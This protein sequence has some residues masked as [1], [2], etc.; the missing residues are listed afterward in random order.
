M[1][2]RSEMI[3]LRFGDGLPLAP[4]AATDPEAL[5]AAL[6]APDALAAAFPRP[7]LGDALAFFREGTKALR[8]VKKNQNETT[9]QAI[10][11]AKR[12]V[13]LSHLASVQ[14]AVAR[15]V[16][17]TDGFRE[18]LVRF[19]ADHF[20]VRAKNRF[21]A[22]FPGAFVD[23]AIRPNLAADFPTLLRAAV[24]HPAMLNYL[25]QSASVGP[26][27][28]IGKRQARGLNENLA[29]EVI[30]LHT[31]G[32]GSG[33]TQA[34]VTQM[35]ELLTGLTV[36]PEKGLVFRPDMAEPGAETV[37]G[38]VY[39]GARTAPI[40]AVLDDIALRPD[41]ARH[42]ARKLAVHFVAD[43]PDPA[44]VAAMADAFLATGG[45][46]PAVYRAMFAQPAAWASPLVKARQ[47]VDFLVAALRGLGVAGQD[48]AAMPT[49]EVGRAIYNPLAAMGQPWQQP[50]GPDGWPEA[51]AFWITPQLLAARVTWAMREPARLRQT[52]PDPS[53]FAARVLGS[54]ADGRTVWAAARAETLADGVGVVL[55]SPGFNRR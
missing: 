30:E 50:R 32:V 19:W 31:L 16:D 8:D 12:K 15:A 41:T 45:N 51:D 28:R 1:I 55:A 9:K 36:S 11:D 5:V 38:Q 46:L 52:L 24:L 26:N 34:D 18:R 14:M 53:A 10:E 42:I 49:T 23:E 44:L 22:L 39:D 33:Y 17:A 2:P 40:H 6:S 4:G 21:Q 48:V 35:A 25:D 20:T 37:L 29:R 47:P 54:A 43:T 7:G 27:S 3:A 13:R